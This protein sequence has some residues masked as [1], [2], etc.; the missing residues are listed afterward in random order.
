MKPAKEISN[1]DKLSPPQSAGWG[2]LVPTRWRT[3]KLGEVCVSK[4][5]TP[6]PADAPDSTFVYVDITSV[7]NVSKRIVAPKELIGRNAPSRARQI[8]RTGNVLLST[9]RPNLNAVALVPPELDGQIAS[10][11][12]CVLRSGEQIDSE[13]L[14]SYVR[15]PQFVSNLTELTKG[16]LYPAV[17][18]KQIFAQIISLPPLDEQKRI[19]A[20]LRERM[21]EVERAR[22]AVQMQLDAA[23][24]LPAALLREIF[25]SAVARRWP[26]ATLGDESQVVGGMQKTPDRAPR[27]FHKQFL[28]VRNVQ[29]GYLDLR[30][31]ER[32]EVTPAEFE[33]LRL[34]R[35]DLLIVE[36]NGSVDHIGR[37]ALFNEEGEWIHQ[38]HIIRVRLSQARLLPDFVSEY[39]NSEA[40]CTQMLE[41]A[42]TTTGLY[43]LSTKKIA[44][45][46]VPMPS[47]VEQR[48]VAARLDT[49]LTAARV[50]VET[51]ETRLAEI[52]LLPAAL[53]RS[54][55]SRQ[56]E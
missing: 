30:N 45:L 7:D 27:E 6:N 52:E 47:L 44:S 32:F 50:L 13:F 16:A 19:A 55:F 46:V 53:L 33:R 14:F 25:A 37:N 41:K 34:H 4:A 8:I 17:N 18:D 15:T 22:A 35:G 29:R 11:G 49:E 21:A 2:Q 31:V 3:V 26:S 56:N 40:G 38:N 51:L 1:G 42:K 48:R 24:S 43:T 20:R 10:T 9:T 54:A 23:Q 5:E 12:F 39:L 36:G 28:T